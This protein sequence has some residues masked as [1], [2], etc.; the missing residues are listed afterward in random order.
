MSPEKTLDGADVAFLGLN[1]GGRFAQG[2]HPDFA[3][4]E[5]STY[6]TES[7]GGAA[8]GESPL[9]RQVR[10]LFRKLDVAPVDVLAGNLVPFRSR[11]WSQL[12]SK[13]TALD[14]GHSL[15]TRILARARPHL[16]IGM[17]GLVTEALVRMFGLGVACRVSLGWGRV[18]GRW[19]K[20]E[21]LEV[22]GLPHL[23]RFS[24]INRPQSQSGLAQLFGHRWL[25]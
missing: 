23:S 16:I 4:I 21:E 8:P 25:A 24:I 14:F 11:D 9:Q 2:D 18:T 7:W 20:S 6:V 10:G 1:P 12:K 15:W 22:V 5:G 13:T 3:P 17:G 19:W